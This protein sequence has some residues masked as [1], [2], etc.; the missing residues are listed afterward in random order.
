MGSC[1]VG[2]RGGDSAAARTCCKRVPQAKLVGLV[3]RLA[4]RRRDGWAAASCVRRI[5]GEAEVGGAGFPAVRSSPLCTAAAGAAHSGGVLPDP[6]RQRQ[7]G[8]AG[9]RCI[10]GGRAGKGRGSCLVVYTWRRRLYACVCVWVCVESERESARRGV[11]E[12]G[13]R[14]RSCVRKQPKRAKISI[15]RPLRWRRW[16]RS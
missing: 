13:G 9:A 12:G 7:H 15:L 4:G 1:G 8:T 10:A 11:A 14:G 2:S 5:N 16:R 6:S 3:A